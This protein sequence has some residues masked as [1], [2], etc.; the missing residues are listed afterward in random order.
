MFQLVPMWSN[1]TY[2]A[3]YTIIVPLIKQ[4]C[5]RVAVVQVPPRGVAQFVT[6]S[7][8]LYCGSFPQTHQERHG[9][10][11]KYKIKTFLTVLLVEQWGYFCAAGMAKQSIV[12]YMSIAS[13]TYGAIQ[14]C[15][16]S[17]GGKTWRKEIF[18]E[19]ETQMGE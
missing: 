19:T 8:E 18:R 12:I 5:L 10:K 7:L 6:C 1:M 14:K 13:S 2:V 3:Y 9:L 4:S 17:F 15:I 11:D 16:Q